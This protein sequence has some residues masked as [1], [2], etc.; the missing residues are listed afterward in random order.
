MS[1][2]LSV[3]KFSGRA[4]ASGLEPLK[5]DSRARS[6]KRGGFFSGVSLERGDDDDS[7]EDDGGVE[8]QSFTLTGVPTTDTFPLSDILSALEKRDQDVP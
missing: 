1:R 5:G 2:G 8:V 3:T 6:G 4:G 7:D